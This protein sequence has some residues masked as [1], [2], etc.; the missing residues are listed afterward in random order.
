MSLSKVIFYLLAVEEEKQQR[1][2]FL[3]EEQLLV[4]FSLFSSMYVCFTCGRFD[5][6]KES[7]DC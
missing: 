5:R 4:A 7:G 2:A 1:E 6:D 3:F